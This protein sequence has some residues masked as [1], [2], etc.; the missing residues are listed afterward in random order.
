MERFFPP[1]IFVTQYDFEKASPLN[2]ALKGGLS[3]STTVR[4]QRHLHFVHLPNRRFGWTVYSCHTSDADSQRRIPILCS[5]LSSKPHSSRISLQIHREYLYR[6][7][8]PILSTL[9]REVACTLRVHN[10]YRNNL[11]NSIPYSTQVEHILRKCA[12]GNGGDNGNADEEKER[13]EK[14]VWKKRPENRPDSDNAGR[15]HF[16]SRLWNQKNSGKQTS[17]E[18]RLWEDLRG[19]MLS[20]ILRHAQVG[21]RERI[22]P[23]RLMGFGR[24]KEISSGNLIG[25]KHE[26]EC[27]FIN[28][29]VIT[30]Q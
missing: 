6:E 12:N 18:I 14:V 23:S 5:V 27:T 9:K 20:F 29:I 28:A 2:S 22:S 24:S 16:P 3:S 15:Q 1:I 8:Q 7:E 25:L 19:K 21:K 17:G 11:S 26:I 10:I 4:S 13:T 30:A